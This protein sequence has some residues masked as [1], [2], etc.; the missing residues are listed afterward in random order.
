MEEVSAPADEGGAAVEVIETIST[1]DEVREE[2]TEEIMDFDLLRREEEEPV[3]PISVEEGDGDEATG[4]AEELS[5]EE[6]PVE[7]NIL[8]GEDGEVVVTAEETTSEAEET[9][10][11]EPAPAAEPTVEVVPEP[12]APEPAVEESA[13]E[14]APEPTPTPEPVAIE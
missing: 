11:E 3:V 10:V 12:Q 2:N 4:E 6:T 9:A 5:I 1:L 8:E 13:P 7:E 14:P